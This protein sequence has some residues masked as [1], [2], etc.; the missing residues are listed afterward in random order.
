MSDW[1][2]WN[3]EKCPVGGYVTVEASLVDWTHKDRFSD[4]IGYRNV[5]ISNDD[6]NN[7][8]R[9]FTKRMNDSQAFDVYDVLS[10]FNVTCPMRQ[11]AIKKLLAAG[12]RSG[13]KSELQDL[14][15]ALWS[16]QEAIKEKDYERN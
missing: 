7:Y 1:I 10:A 6:E 4:I 11:H 2:K 15:E 3:G 13:G 14:Q 9:K 12:Q 5:L 8:A 16:V